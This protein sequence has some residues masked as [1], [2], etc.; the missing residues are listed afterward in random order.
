MAGITFTIDIGTAGRA[1]MSSASLVSAGIDMP[2]QQAIAG[3]ST[4]TRALGISWSRL[5]CQY[6]GPACFGHAP[7]VKLHCPRNEPVG[8]APS[9]VFSI[10]V[11]QRTGEACA[12]F[13]LHEKR[14]E[15]IILTS[16]AS[17]YARA[18]RAERCGPKSRQVKGG[19]MQERLQNKQH[20][21]QALTPCAQR[22]QWIRES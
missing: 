13:L 9:D 11:P 21:R 1:S 19:E 2:D 10:S 7:G 14:N 16:H 8:Q 4:C 20:I 18:G 17:N 6:A 3:T 12:N 5:Y 22:K 15:Q